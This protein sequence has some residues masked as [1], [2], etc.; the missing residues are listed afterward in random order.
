MIAATFTPMAS[1]GSL[2]DQVE[3]TVLKVVDRAQRSSSYVECVNARI[4]TVQ[5]ARK[6]LSE[7]FVY[8]VAVYHN[9]KPFGRGSV[10][11]GRTPAQLAGIALP[12]EDWIELLDLMQA[13]GSDERAAQAA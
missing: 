3:I 8:L 6:R 1:D 4:R 13:A 12:T 11:E 7:D 5:V 10:R 9:L 2:R